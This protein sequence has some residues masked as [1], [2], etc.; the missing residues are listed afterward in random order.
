MLPDAQNRRTAAHASGRSPIDS[1]AA[2]RT[3]LCPHLWSQPA[4]GASVARPGPAA[5][6]TAPH[7]RGM[8]DPRSGCPGN[9]RSVAEGAP[10]SLSRP[11][12]SA[13][14]LMVVDASVLVPHDVHHA[15]SRVWLTR[16]AGEDGLIVAP[17]LLLPEIAGAVARRTGT[18]RLAA[19][20]VDAVPRLPGLRLV[21]IDDAL[22]RTAARLAGRLRLR[23]TDAVYVATAATLRLPLVT[24]DVEQRE[25]SAHVIEVGTPAEA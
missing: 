20:A 13:R 1:L 14:S 10:G 16:Q 18:P 4:S 17:A 22:A 24:W 25:R 3:S 11:R 19:R 21:S 8:V 15:A 5:R 9:R 23:G 12:G 2:V 6:A 7:P